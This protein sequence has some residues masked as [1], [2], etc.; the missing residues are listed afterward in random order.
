MVRI[1]KAV[2]LFCNLFFLIIP[3][4]LWAQQNSQGIVKKT[5]LVSG[6]KTDILFPAEKISG[7]ILVLPGWSFSRS[8][9]CEK[10][11]FCELALKNGYVLIMPEMGKSIY[12]SQ[13]FHETRNDW[14]PYPTLIWI[15]DSLIPYCQKEFNLL[16]PGHN[17]YL[18]GISTGGR[19]VALLSIYAGNIFIAGAALSGDYNQL[20]DTSDNLIRGF[21]GDFNKFPERWKGK[22]NPLMNANKL[23]IPLFLAH[24]KSD[25]IV[26]Y[27]QSSIFFDSIHKI[28]P[29]LGHRLFLKNDAGHNYKFWNT[30]YNDVFDFFQKHSGS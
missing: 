11:N 26:P 1:K 23:N 24:G 14:R 18:F 21:Y 3:S 28:R 8:D 13:L 6:V 20:S 12:A 2:I 9:I 4:K 5:F 25:L 15:T 7:S 17:N 22:D 30:E 19:G 10:S 16:I 29:E 27:L